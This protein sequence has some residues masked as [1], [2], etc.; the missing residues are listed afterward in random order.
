MLKKLVAWPLQESAPDLQSEKV[1]IRSSSLEALLESEA[2]YSVV[3]ETLTVEQV[4]VIVESAPAC[5]RP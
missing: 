2:G 3:V 1:E 4:P 5:W